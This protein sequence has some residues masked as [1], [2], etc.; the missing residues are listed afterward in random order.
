MKHI[1]SYN[2]IKWFD[3]SKVVDF[4]KEPL[5]VYHGTKNSFDVFNKINVNEPSG[6]YVGCGYFFT[7]DKNKAYEYGHI[8]IPVYLKIINPIVI[9]N[10]YDAKKLRDS[11][12]GENYYKLKNENPCKIQEELI[13]RGYDGLIDYSYNQY[14]VF[15][16]NQIKSVDNYGDWNENNNNIYL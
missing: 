6:D 8:I 13:N 1:H 4:D 2:F 14:A 7:S 10:S 11:F 15:Y 9:Y 3:D 12:G 16:P 5:I